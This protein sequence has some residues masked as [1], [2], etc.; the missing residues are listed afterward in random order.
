L[1]RWR[2][3]ANRARNSTPITN[4]RERVRNGQ[5]IEQY[6]SSE[7]QLINSE[8]VHLSKNL[9]FLKMIISILL[10]SWKNIISKINENQ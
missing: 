3:F 10:K 4:R 1:S 9:I 6:K 7:M 2:G 8:N 5:T